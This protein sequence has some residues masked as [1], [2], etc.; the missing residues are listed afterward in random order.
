MHMFDKLPATI[1]CICCTFLN[2]FDHAIFAQCNR[3]M[4][5]IAK[6]SETHDYVL[7]THLNQL[8]YHPKKLRIMT[9]FDLPECKSVTHLDLDNDIKG[10]TNLRNLEFLEASVPLDSIT[11]LTK[12]T[13]ITCKRRYR[14]GAQLPQSI[15]SIKIRGYPENNLTAYINTIS[16]FQIEHLSLIHC[17]IPDLSSLRLTSLDILKYDNI[18]IPKMNIPTLRELNLSLPRWHEALD[19]INTNQIPRLHLHIIDNANLEHLH[20][21]ARA[22]VTLEIELDE[23]QYLP[24][25]VLERII[26]VSIREGGAF[27]NGSSL[28]QM[29]RLKEL[30]LILL[31]DK[32]SIMIHCDNARFHHWP[33]LYT[34][35]IRG[36]IMLIYDILDILHHSP[37]PVNCRPRDRKAPYSLWVT[38][39]IM[40][41]IRDYLEETGMQ[42]SFHL[43][44]YID[45]FN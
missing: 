23:C 29:S 28:I 12:L 8:Q 10:L 21:I 5:R 42:N 6:N 39:N 13:H 43:N 9:V 27:W 15:R 25:C 1:G 32:S 33:D 7:L 36:D 4:N 37:Q 44:N 38:E 16:Q 40:Q 41:D 35:F 26:R 19:N 31:R 2:I 18:E 20:K 22:D 14:Y 45:W 34:M 3:L 17:H 11:S 24:I 30:S